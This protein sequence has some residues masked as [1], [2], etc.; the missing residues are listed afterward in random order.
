MVKSRLAVDAGRVTKRAGLCC[1]FARETKNKRK[2]G[3]R[4]HLEEWHKLEETRGPGTRGGGG[5]GGEVRHRW[6]K[7]NTQGKWGRRERQNKT[8]NELKWTKKKLK[9][10]CSPTPL[11]QSVHKT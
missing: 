3:S 9:G 8:G 5:V 7:D 11:R 4:A 6:R 2:V 1:R 10:L